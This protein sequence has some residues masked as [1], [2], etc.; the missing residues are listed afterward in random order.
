VS[1]KDYYEILGVAS[2]TSDDAI[3]SAYRKLAIK[4][5]PD[6]NSG[7]KKAEDKFKEVTEAYEVLSDKNKR[8]QYDQ[9]GHAA[10]QGGT[11]PSGFGST[12]HAEDVFRSVFEGLG[13][14]GGIFGDILE[15]AFGGSTSRQRRSSRR[16]SDLEM[17]M[18]ISFEEAAFGVEKS[19]NIPRHE[20]CPTCKGQGAAPG[21]SKTTC[22]YCNGKGQ[23]MSQAGFF[24][25]ARTCPQCHGEGE[26]IQSPCQ[27]CRGRGRVKVQRKIDVKIPAGVDTG[28]RVRVYGEGEA[29]QR[30]GER[31]DLY[32]LI[33]VK[34]HSIFKRDEN[35]ILCELPVSFVQATLGDEVEVPTLYGRVKM[36]I[37]ASTQSGKIFRLRQKGITD[38]HGY[39]KGDQLVRVTVEIPTKLS[40]KQ[41]QLLREFDSLGGGS[42]PGI[43]S[44][45]DKIR[46]AFK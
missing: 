28:T 10:F 2:N 1:K 35:N 20:T 21:T 5:H 34:K 16:G 11:G 13:G 22:S 27:E 3:K 37:P 44:F 46:G 6:K 33:Y 9:F 26:I 14:S 4:Y 45:M 31:G 25:V 40:T 8:T 43:A 32:I 39:G 36:K 18:E 30:G 41:R 19:V 24:S 7:D 23:V 12:A 17:S 15:G 29:G 42:T 38:V